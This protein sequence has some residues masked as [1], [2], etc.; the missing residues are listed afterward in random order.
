[1]T[2]DDLKK[3]L[4]AAA[5]IDA[6]P[7]DPD[8]DLQRAQVAYVR[9]RRRIRRGAT[10]LVTAAVIGTGGVIAL[11]DRAS[12]APT[13]D[14]GTGSDVELVAKT[15]DADPYT[16]DLTPE[17]WS[18]EAQMPQGVTIVPDDGSTS[19][20]PSDFR[21]K[22]VIMFDQNPPHGEPTDHD[23]RRFWVTNNPD[24]TIISTRTAGDEPRGMV[25]IQYPADTGWQRPTM[26]EFLGSVHVGPGAQP[27]L[28]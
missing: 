6:E 17:G 25:R 14:P 24:A 12:E 26:I 23:G 4:G 10:A 18:V 19:N 15:L 21:G 3:A 7:V 11:Q 27:G 1:M 13:A 5:T 28:G 22:L 20:N 2:S 8:A 16:F 9:S